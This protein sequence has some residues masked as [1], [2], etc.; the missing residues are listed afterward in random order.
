MSSSAVEIYWKGSNSLPNKPSVWKGC[1]H[2][3]EEVYEGEDPW[4]NYGS[5][6]SSTI[7]EIERCA[8]NVYANAVVDVEIKYFNTKKKSYREITGTAIRYD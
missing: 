2:L 3:V 6:K 4:V 5:G 7:Y 8:S 1:I